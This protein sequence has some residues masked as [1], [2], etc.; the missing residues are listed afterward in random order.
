VGIA[1]AFKNAGIGVGL[2]D[3]G[4]C[5]LSIEGG[6]LH[7]RTSAA[8]L[9]QGLATV[10]T[11]IACQTTGIPPERTVVE[12]PDTRRTPNSGTTT[13]SRQTVF[14]GEA[15]RRASVELREA[16]DEVPG[17]SLDAAIA[18]LEGREF[19][20][21]FIGITDPMGSGKPHP[22]SHVSYSY[23]ATVVTLDDAGKVERVSA[24]Y[25]L[26]TVINPKAAE[27]QIEGGILMG[28]G[29]ALT[30]DFPLEGGYP[31]AKYATLG[32]LRSTDAPVMDI[33]MM[34][35]QNPTPL[36]YGAKG[37]GE[38][39]TIPVCPAVA[40]AYY[41]RDGRLRTKLPMDGTAYQKE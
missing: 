31:R 25:D 19:L 1:C 41:S 20:N 21:E 26:G 17:E 10:A 35:P 37:V 7:I 3:V 29:Y 8:C 33:A 24:A 27:G 28:L 14:T 38:L 6:V 5:L 11:Q 30:E 18:R 39:A 13:A 32:L 22:K 34:K 40:G 9:G 2:P 15:V 12:P 36:T 16:M 4:R 23:A